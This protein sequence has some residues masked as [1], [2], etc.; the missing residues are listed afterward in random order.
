M[1]TVDA[2]EVVIIGDKSFKD[3]NITLEEIKDIFLVKK[4]FLDGKKIL[5]MNYEY[6]NPMRHCFEKMVL[7][8][9][10]RSIERYWQKAYYRGIRPPKII[11]STTMLFNYMQEIQPSIGYLY[12]EE[13][14]PKDTTILFQVECRE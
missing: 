3:K 8:K 1:V 14:F 11:K 10:S 4:R 13:K 5:V 2:K 6:D 7:K 9:S 12:K